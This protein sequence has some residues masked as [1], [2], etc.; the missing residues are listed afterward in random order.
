[1]L[2]A[3]DSAISLGDFVEIES[4]Q[5]QNYDGSPLAI[6]MQVIKRLERQTGTTWAFTARQ[7]AFGGATFVNRV[8]YIDGGYADELF[9]LNL[10]SA[11]DRRYDPASLTAGSIVEFIITSGIF[12]SSSTTSTYALT[13][14]NTWPSGVFVSLV[15]ESGAIVAGR[16]GDGGRGGRAFTARQFAFGGAT[17]VNR[18]IYIDGSYPDEL[19]DL[20]LKSA[21]DRRY[22]PASLTAG[23]I[24][25]FIITSGI[26]VSGSTTSTYAL[27]NPNTWPIGVFVRLVIESGAIVAGR[28]GNGGNG[29]VFGDGSGTNGGNGGKAFNI[30]YAVSVLNNGI[31]SGGSGGGGGG[32]GGQD[33][34]L[35]GL[36][37]GGG[38]GWPY[39]SGGSGG[40]GTGANGESGISALGISSTSGGLGGA[41]GRSSS[42]GDF[43]QGGAGGQ[44]GNIGQ[45]GNVGQTGI[46]ED[47]G[48][49]G[50][51]GNLGESING[52][53]FVTFESTGT[54]YGATS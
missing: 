3:K 27:T 21:R 38:G 32:G 29:S 39:G 34:F 15:I 43:G 25:E 37:G 7:F 30:Q 33:S 8:I 4:K 47:F 18:V 23:S 44:G 16:G 26:L 5:N 40:S 24:V 1:M 12:I 54:I 9:D 13:N 28:G 45:N 51:G 19:F 11:H 48:F 2:D 52:I 36:G 14:P 17:F 49:G 53:S 41:G 22:D 31:I 6:L 20:N 50:S 10:K 35:I 42:G 46:G